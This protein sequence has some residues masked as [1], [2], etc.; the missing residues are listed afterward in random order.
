MTKADRIAPRFLTTETAHIEVYGRLGKLVGNMK[1]ISKTG[2]YLELTQGDYVPNL[3]D[4][5]HMTVHLHSMRK[6][7]NMDAEVVWNKGLTFGV[8]FVNKEQVLE[9]IFLKTG[10]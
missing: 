6:T 9:K 10:T 4:V 5:L 1:N 8:Q 7:H 2:A 3:G